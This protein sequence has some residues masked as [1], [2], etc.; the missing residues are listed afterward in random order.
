MINELQG[1]MVAGGFGAIGEP[2]KE[3]LAR[4]RALAEQKIFQDRHDRQADTSLRLQ[5][6]QTAL[7][8]GLKGEE[9]VKE[10]R[11]Y[12]DFITAAPRPEL[13]KAPG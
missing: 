3:A 8:H 1:K 5:C 6:I 7:A 10:A 2:G 4:E 13:V 11:R 12:Y 9:A